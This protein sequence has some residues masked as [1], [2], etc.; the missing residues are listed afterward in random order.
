[1]AQN[2]TEKVIATNKSAFHDY[3]VLEKFEAGIVLTGDEVKSIKNGN[4]NLK[5][6]F[7][8]AE[9]RS[10]I[11]KNMHVSVYE[12]SNGF[13]LKQ[14]R[15]DRILLMHKLEVLRISQKVERK[16][17]TLIPIRIY[18]KGALIKFEI[19]LCQGKH[20]Y[21]KKRDLMEKDTNRQTQREIKNYR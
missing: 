20:T 5:D 17:L 10:L 8:F 13:A 1:M 14:E 7:I 2:C 21:D 9:N 3:F 6:S 19:A 12:K 4:V 18:L 11:I 16:G 15:R